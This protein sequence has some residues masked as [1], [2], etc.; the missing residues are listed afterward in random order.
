MLQN[1]WYARWKERRYRTVYQ[2]NIENGKGWKKGV[3]R[4]I[5]AKIE[6]QWRENKT[7]RE[8]Q[9]DFNK[10]IDAI[11]ESNSGGLDLAS[12]AGPTVNTWHSHN[13]VELPQIRALKVIGWYVHLLSSMRSVLL[14][15][16]VQVTAQILHTHLRVMLLHPWNEGAVQAQCAVTLLTYILI[17][18]RCIIC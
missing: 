10:N 11:S 6:W 5:I 3:K 18:H 15:C 4:K 17:T 7:E 8:C 14:K 1:V 2:I 16:S 9:A 12:S 13:D